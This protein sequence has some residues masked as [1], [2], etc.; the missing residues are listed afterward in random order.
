MKV[1]AKDEYATRAVLD[2]ALNQEMNPVS[3]KDISSRQAI[4]ERFLEQ[5]M[6]SL[7]KGGLVESVR[8]A[9]GGYRLARPASKISL[10][11]VVV[12]SEGPIMLMDC[13][14]SER[15]G[16]CDR[17]SYCVI[18]D[19]WREVQSSMVDVLK[20]VTIKDLCDKKKKNEQ[21]KSYMFHI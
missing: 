3:V 7:K 19:T 12:A 20:S 13:I 2:I 9:K 5:I 11:D 14:D 6:T 10:A 15:K 17:V 8:G 16:S 4:P 1:S 18:R 21:D